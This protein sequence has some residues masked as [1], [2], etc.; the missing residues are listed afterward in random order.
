MDDVGPDPAQQ[1]ARRPAQS[2]RRADAEPG[3]PRHRHRA[4][5]VL[6]DRTDLFGRTAA[7]PPCRCRDVDLVPALGQP[8][9][10]PTGCVAGT[11][12]VRCPGVGAYQDAH[13]FS[14]REAATP[15]R[16]STAH[17]RP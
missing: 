15:R 5:P 17:A 7:E 8:G 2:R 16:A 10:Q 12:D 14:F 4:D 6:G 13:T 9:R 11:V 1:G 3:R